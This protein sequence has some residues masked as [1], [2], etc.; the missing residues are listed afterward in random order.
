[1]RLTL[2]GAFAQSRN[3]TGSIVGEL[4][5]NSQ[6]P[7][8]TTVTQIRRDDII[9]LDAPRRKVYRDGIHQANRE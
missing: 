9:Q 5:K 4:L 6:S 7:V 8:N 1:M 2:N 3:T